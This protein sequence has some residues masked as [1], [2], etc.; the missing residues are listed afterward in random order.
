MQ[1]LLTLMGN[2]KAYDNY[3]LECYA[4]VLPR[5][6]DGVTL[7]SSHASWEEIR[8]LVS[9]DRDLSMITVNVAYTSLAASS[10]PD[11]LGM[12]MIFGQISSI[13]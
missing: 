4:A 9:P 13:D 3:S 11:E 6:D 1:F 12:P 8:Q 10:S 5:V 2:G 7:D